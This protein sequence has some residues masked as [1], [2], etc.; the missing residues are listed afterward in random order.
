MTVS[1]PHVMGESWAAAARLGSQKESVKV[2]CNDWTSQVA[3]TPA[4]AGSVVVG[5]QV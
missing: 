2:I 4:C 1:V 3:L 5:G